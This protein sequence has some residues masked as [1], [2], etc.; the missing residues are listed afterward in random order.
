MRTKT[1]TVRIVG[2]K[3][4]QAKCDFDVL[5]QPEI[6]DARD[7]ILG[8]MMRGGK[9]LGVQRNTLSA[10]PRGL[11]ATV[12]STLISPRTKGV[13]WGRYQEKVVKGIVARNA[14]KKA[15]SRIE[16]RWAQSAGG[17]D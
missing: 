7:T 2:L 9:G 1:S 15:I 6:E 10:H 12:T 13:A 11:A 16:A 3:E 8:R 14:I 17:L 5:V 4:L